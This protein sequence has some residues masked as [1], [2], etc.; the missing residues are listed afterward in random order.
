MLLG[1]EQGPDVEPV[2]GVGE[3]DD[4]GVVMEP[5]VELEPGHGA[6]GD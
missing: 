4:F 6:S 1:V 2:G 3:A 5:A